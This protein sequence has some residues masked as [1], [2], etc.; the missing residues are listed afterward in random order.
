VL[1][2]ALTADDADVLASWGDDRAFRVEAGWSTEL[3]REQIARFHRGIVECP[4]PELL[5]LAATVDDN[6]VGYVDLHGTEVGRRELG[7]LVGPRSAWGRGL[8][9]AVA[10]AGLVHAFDVLGLDEVWAETTPT[11]AA[12]RRILAR[13]GLRENGIGDPRFA[14]SRSAWA[15][16]GHEPGDT[17]PDS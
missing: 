8:G 16:R 17:S 14:V 6:L 15:A 7:F 2:R 4:P 1:L 13:V 12:S 9:T 11:N 10:R 3:S 5:R